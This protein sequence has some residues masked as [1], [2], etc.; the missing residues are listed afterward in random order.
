MTDGDLLFR[1]FKGILTENFVLTSL[2]RQFGYEPVY[3]KSGNQAEIEFV[4]VYKNRI[5]PI[6][7]KSSESVRSKSLTEFRKKY[8]PE[9]SLRYSMKNL[10]YE[11]GLINIPLYL[12]DFTEQILKRMIEQ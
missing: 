10:K 7:A 12:A 8:Q 2:I 11:D 5:I 3:W 1:E 9:I 6:E 4:I